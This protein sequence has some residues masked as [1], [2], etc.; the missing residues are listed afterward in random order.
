MNLCHALNTSC[1]RMKQDRTP[2]QG[3]TFTSYTSLLGMRAAHLGV[4]VGKVVIQGALRVRCP[5]TALPIAGEIVLLLEIGVIMVRG[6]GWVLQVGL[7]D[8]P[9]LL[10]AVWLGGWGARVAGVDV[11]GGARN[12]SRGPWTSPR[13]QAK[14]LHVSVQCLGEQRPGCIQ[15]F[16]WDQSTGYGL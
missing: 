11:W 4:T 3:K 5:S 13:A 9:P 15:G 2:T 14:V 10:V 16:K 7:R 12:C 6:L 1:M 8:Y